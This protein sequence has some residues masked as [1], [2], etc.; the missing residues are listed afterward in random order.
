MKNKKE[1][2]S[3]MEGGVKSFNIFVMGVLVI[4]NNQGS[5][6]RFQKK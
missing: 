1:N 2:L 5:K 4:E 6:I 3:E